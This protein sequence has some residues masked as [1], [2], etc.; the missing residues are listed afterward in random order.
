MRSVIVLGAAVVMIAA[1]GQLPG[2]RPAANPRATRSVVLA[3]NGIIATSQPLAS[4]AGLRVLQQ[5]GNAIDA[6]V[7]AAAV[8]SVVEP[9]MNGLGGDLFAIVYDAKTKTVRG[10]N[11][12][13][14]A[15]AAATPAEFTR[16]G[17]TDIPYR[18]VLSVS[19]PGVVDGWHELLSKYGTHYAG[20]RDRTGDWL[21]ARWIRRQRDHRHPMEG[22]RAGARAAIRP[23]R[24]R[25]CPAAARPRPVTSSA[26]RSSLPR[27]SR[28]RAADATRSI[29]G[30]LA[31]RSPPTS[32]GATA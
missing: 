22:R 31:P 13:G 23:R 6:A 24:R 3:R 7:T 25:F 30:L 28:L 11:A 16:R 5:G 12:S 1:D 18:G 4:A 2:D 9:T 29:A 8:L 32:S 14:R 20:A 19:V 27:W 10:L 26:I 21:R 15:S 17:L